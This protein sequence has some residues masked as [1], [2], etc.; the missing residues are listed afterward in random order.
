MK[1]LNLD[2]KPLKPHLGDVLRWQ[3]GLHRERQARS[4]STGVDVPTVHNDGRLLRRATRDGL[5]WIG[6]ASFLV[7]LGG[8]SVLIDPVMSATL[9]GLVPRNVAPGLSWMGLPARIDMVLITHDHRDH[10]DTPTLRTLGTEV[11]FVVPE[12]LGRW[13]KRAGLRRVKEMVWWEQAELEGVNVTF[14]PSQHWSRRALLDANQSWWGGYVLE[15]GGMRVYHSGDTG[16]FEGFEMIRQR[17]GGEIQAAMLPIGA[18]A[19]RWF[20]RHQHMDPDEAVRAFQ[21]LG[22]RQFVGMHWGTFKL[23][24]EPLTEPPQR[25]ARAWAAQNL[26]ESRC[27]LPAI[28]QTLDLG[29]VSA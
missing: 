4:P 10:M 12:G 3:M 18:Y 21:A 8:R 19:P 15:R 13:F 23:T 26:P 22:A 7:Q 11:L 6:H 20:M 28:G 14:V 25:L 24:D 1:Y 5:T 17:V 29:T 16:W 27:Q 9:G 2:G